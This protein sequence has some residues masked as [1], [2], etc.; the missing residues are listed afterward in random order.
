METL[1]HSN[2]QRWSPRGHILKSLASKLQVLEN[3]P[4]L[5]SRTAVGLCLELLKFCGAPE[6][7]F[8]R[9]FFLKITWKKFWRPFFG[10]NLHLCSWSLALSILF[11]SLE[12]VCPWKGC[13]WPW[14]KIFLVSLA[15]A[16][17]LV[18]STTPLLITLLALLLLVL[19]SLL[20][21]L[22]YCLHFFPALVNSADKIKL[23]SAQR[24]DSM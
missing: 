21:R 10:E 13:P 24:N 20:P 3:W 12:K 1:F 14:S 18:S 7:L 23:T 4:I 5:G 9:R 6:K 15:L 2:N 11:L 22:S 8:G 16:S 19:R 17:S